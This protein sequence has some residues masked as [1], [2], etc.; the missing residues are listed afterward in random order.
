ME[1]IKECYE[2]LTKSEAFMSRDEDA[3]LSSVSVMTDY[4][5][6]PTSKWQMD[7]YSP[8]KKKIMSFLMQESIQIRTDQDMFQT[9][10]VQEVEISKL[11]I[12]FSD[13]MQKSEAILKTEFDDTPASIIA[14][15]QKR[16]KMLWII[17][18]VTTSM[19]V[20][21]IE[22]DAESGD[23]VSKKCGSVMGG[24]SN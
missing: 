11:N 8:S 21:C 9:F 6:L 10:S 19:K 2:R 24:H 18:F 15:L 1:P 17:T 5:K 14:V 22:I 7:F 23:I 20:A 4:S 12:D 16:D 3:F 13:V